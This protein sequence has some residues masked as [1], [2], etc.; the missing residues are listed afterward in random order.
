MKGKP[1]QIVWYN[2]LLLFLTNKYCNK[3]DIYLLLFIMQT[4]ASMSRLIHLKLSDNLTFLDKAW[5]VRIVK[6][7][8]DLI[9]KTFYL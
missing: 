7:Y 8:V 2:V 1:Y 4:P 5:L 6:C 9:I 3:T